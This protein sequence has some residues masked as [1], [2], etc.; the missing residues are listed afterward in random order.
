MTPPNKDTVRV[1]FQTETSL[2]TRAFMTFGLN[3]KPNT[4]SPIGHFGTGLKYAIAVC[5]REG[6][7]ISIYADEVWFE[8]Y[9]KESDFRGEKVTDIKYKKRRLQPNKKWKMV[10]H[11]RLPFTTDLGKEWELWQAFREI[12][13]N[14]LDEDGCTACVDAVSTSVDDLVKNGRTIVVVEGNAFAQ[15]YH[16]RNDIFLPNATRYNTLTDVDGNVTQLPDMEVFDAPSRYIYYRGIRV[17]DLNAHN[18]NADAQENP[19]K[20]RYTYNLIGDTSLTEDRTLAYAYGTLSRIGRWIMQHD[21]EAWIRDVLEVDGDKFWEGKIDFNNPSITPSAEFM[22][23]YRSAANVLS[24]AR[25]FMKA[26]D[27]P[28]PPKRR[29][30]LP[31]SDIIKKLGMIRKNRELEAWE[32]QALDDAIAFI[33]THRKDGEVL[34]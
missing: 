11:G 6:C 10:S 8:F 34:F 26:Y 23:A 33:R 7:P 15:V 29:E 4:K 22:R 9:G 27:A 30:R 14:T 20:S 25:T 1:E 31:P 13:S 17:L 24:S 19:I 2:D 28:P 18:Y 3:A 12:Q 32:T 21:D 16:N 5:V